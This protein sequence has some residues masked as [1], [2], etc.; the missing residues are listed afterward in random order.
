MKIKSIDTNVAIDVQKFGA[1]H[2]GSPLMNPFIQTGGTGFPLMKTYTPKVYI[3]TYELTADIYIVG[4]YTQLSNFVFLSLEIGCTNYEGQTGDL[5][6]D[7]PTDKIPPN[8]FPV[9]GVS[10]NTHLPVSFIGYGHYD[11]FIGTFNQIIV[12]RYDGVTVKT[13]L[14]S[15]FNLLLNCFYNMESI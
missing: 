4:L 6:I 11:V 13:A 9:Y 5:Y 7:L 15:G 8:S 1:P 2:S 14:P 12:S 3:G 10:I